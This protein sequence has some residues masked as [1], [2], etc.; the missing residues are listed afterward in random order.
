MVSCLPAPSAYV[1]GWL[2]CSIADVEETS[3]NELQVL[4][5]GDLLVRCYY[6]EVLFERLDHQ[7]AQ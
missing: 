4:S 5:R 3:L 6:V 7:L 2:C 1:A